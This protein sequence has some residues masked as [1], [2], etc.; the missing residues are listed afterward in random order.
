VKFAGLVIT[1]L[2]FF[3]AIASLGVT[4]STKGRLAIVLVGIAISVVGSLGVLNRAYLR[5]A[6]WKK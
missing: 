6:I 2:G 5:H 1:A 3:V 4:Q